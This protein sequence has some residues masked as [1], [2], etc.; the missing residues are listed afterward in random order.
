MVRKLTTLPMP[1]TSHENFL[2]LMTELEQ[3]V[4]S[5][6]VMWSAASSI[7]AWRRIAKLTAAVQ[8]LATRLKDEQ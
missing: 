6:E 5:G 8:Q 3:V 1:F 2:Y 4:G 7:A